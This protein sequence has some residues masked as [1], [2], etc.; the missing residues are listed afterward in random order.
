MSSA[1]LSAPSTPTEQIKQ[2][3]VSSK[4]KRK[5]HNRVHFPDDESLVTCY[6]EPP[7]PWSKGNI[8]LLS[9]CQN[10]N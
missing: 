3:N 7:D 2:T 1:S 10:F 9:I 8:Y 4:K 5:P 6:L